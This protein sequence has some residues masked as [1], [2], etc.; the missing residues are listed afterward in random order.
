MKYLLFAFL[1][2]AAA[3]IGGCG[4][5]EICRVNGDFQKTSRDSLP[6]FENDT[7]KIVYFFWDDGGAMSFAIYNKLSVPIYVD[8]ERSA[9][10]LNDRRINYYEDRVVSLTQ[11][12]ALSAQ[13]GYRYR[14]GIAESSSITTVLKSEKTSF[15][16]P[17]SYIVRTG[18]KLWVGIAGRLLENTPPMKIKDRS[19]YDVAGVG[20]IYNESQSPLRF[21]NFLCYSF[22]K[23]VSQPQY[24]DNRFF[25]SSTVQIKRSDFDPQ[26]FQNPGNFYLR[27]TQ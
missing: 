24:I 7:I 11:T 14:Y 26:Y 20:V 12:D 18:P 5:A 19:G 10:I 1:L 16:A 13:V 25:L 9:F 27:P 15:L 21:R 2:C 8:W 22:L 17:H 4:Y 3:Q 6:I 23:D